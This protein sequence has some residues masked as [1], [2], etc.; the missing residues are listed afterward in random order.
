MQMA[1]VL[2][3]ILALVL[4]ARTER[5]DVYEIAPHRGDDAPRH[6]L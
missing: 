3:S 2:L 5:H 4:I 6:D 1:L